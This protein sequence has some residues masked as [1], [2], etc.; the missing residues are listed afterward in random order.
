M[1]YF[2]YWSVFICPL[3]THIPILVYVDLFT[4]TKLPYSNVSLSIF[5]CIHMPSHYTHTHTRL[6]RSIYGDEVALFKC[7]SV[8]IPLYSKMAKMWILS[9]QSLSGWRP[10]R[11]MDRMDR[12]RTSIDER[13]VSGRCAVMIVWWA[14]AR[15]WL[16]FI[17]LLLLVA[18]TFCILGLDICVLAYWGSVALLLSL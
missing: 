13:M 16:F 10:E 12:P 7:F 5:I 17:D 9:G 11:A 1:F 4:V 6:H 14:V 15:F 8:H 2:P 3:T 18:A